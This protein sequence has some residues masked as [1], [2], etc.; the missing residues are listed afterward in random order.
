[1]A[2][3]VVHMAK[4]AVRSFSCASKENLLSFPISRMSLHLSRS[5]A[6]TQCLKADRLYTETHEWIIVDGKVGIIGIS[7]HAQKSLGD[8]VYAQLPDVE[9]VIEKGAEVG[10]LES[11]KAVSDLCSPISGKVIEKNEAV[12]KTPA[13]INS[14]CYDKGWLFKVELSNLDEIK[15]LMNEEAYNSYLKSDPH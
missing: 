3:L 14:S 15:D 7:D 11:V 10:A 13:I 2:K 8:V 9:S 6:T 1:M 12:E 5:I 4:Y